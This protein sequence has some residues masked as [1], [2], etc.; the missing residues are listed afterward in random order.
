MLRVLWTLYYIIIGVC[1]VEPS[2]Y[3]SKLHRNA[4]FAT[5][6][7]IMRNSPEIMACRLQT[8]YLPIC[9]IYRVI[10]LYFGKIFPSTQY[11]NI[12][13]SITCTK[14]THDNILYALQWR[15]CECKQDNVNSREISLGRQFAYY[16]R[17]RVIRRRLLLRKYN[18]I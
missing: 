9:Y 7:R 2:K 1:F 12:F 18:P 11:N 14:Q 6:R 8:C 5:E 15:V 16:T 4:A 10:V 17:H 3:F 13:Y